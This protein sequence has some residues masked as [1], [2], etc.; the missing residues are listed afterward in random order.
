MPLNPLFSAT[1]TRQLKEKQPRP[2][3][4]YMGHDAESPDPKT[5]IPLFP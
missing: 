5:K 1:K 4:V 3:L 2:A